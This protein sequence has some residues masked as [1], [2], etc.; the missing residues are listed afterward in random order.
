MKTP[1]KKIGRQETLP[2]KRE[3]CPKSG[4]KKPEGATQADYPLSSFAKLPWR[5][6][7]EG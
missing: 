1:A 3:G 2:E 5:R 6:D 7:R 4:K